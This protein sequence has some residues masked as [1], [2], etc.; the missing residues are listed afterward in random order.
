[1]K[2]GY[3]EKYFLS[4]VLFLQLIF[5]L[6]IFLWKRPIKDWIFVYLFDAITNG[7][8]DEIL[9][10]YK[11]I[12]YPI[13]LFS[14]KTK[15]NVLFDFLV[16]PLFTVYFNQNTLKDRPFLILYK[17][18]FFTIPMYFFEIWA[19]QKTN[20]IKWQNGWKGYHSFLSLTIKS[21]IT[22]LFIEL[23]RRRRKNSELHK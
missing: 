23:I 21:L 6:P 1:M 16:Y 10:R 15:I 7:I 4:A 5:F 22:R 14:Q 18:L 2:K 12:K 9:T 20:L 11:I 17:L 13:R 8:L 19:V 3:F